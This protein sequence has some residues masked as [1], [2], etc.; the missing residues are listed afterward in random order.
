[1][2]TYRSLLSVTGG[3]S[4][5]CTS[6]DIKWMESLHNLMDMVKVKCRQCSS[7]LDQ[8][9]IYS[10]SRE[11]MMKWWILRLGF[12]FALMLGAEM[13]EGVVVVF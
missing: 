10:K 2:K 13:A 3:T 5:H 11:A 1:M 7:R 4:E 12:A 6:A 9:L 8:K